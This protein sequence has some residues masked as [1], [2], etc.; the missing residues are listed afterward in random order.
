MRWTDLCSLAFSA[1]LRQ[2]TRTGLTL[3]GV[4]I[5]TFALVVTFSVGWGVQGEVL[6]QLRNNNQLRQVSVR[7]GPGKVEAEMPPD[8]LDVKGD[9]SDAKRARIR[10]ALIRDWA[11]RHNARPRVPLDRRRLGVL[12]RL[13]HVESVTPFV[14][15]PCRV[16]FHGKTLDVDC[17]SAAPDNRP[18]RQRVA[19][20][21]FLPAPAGRSVVVHEFLLYRVGIRTDDEVASVI[22]QPIRIEQRAR[23][24]TPTS[25]LTLFSTARADLTSREKEVLEKAVQRLPADAGKLGLS[26][27]DKKT[28]QE[29]FT[30]L[31]SHVPP[32][33]R[34]RFSEE[35]TIA[36]VLRG[37]EKGDHNTS[38]GL[39]SLVLEPDVVMPVHTAEAL[40]DRVPES[41]DE[42]EG[43]P[44]ATLTVDRE[45]NLAGVVQHVK[46]MG[47]N[48]FSLLKLVEQVRRNMTLMTFAV[49]FLAV[50][51]LLVS[52]LG[53]TNTM[54]MA[55][56]ERRKEI[57]IMKAVGARDRHIQLIF[58]LEGALIG[59]VGSAVGLLAAWL[60]S[61]P[62]DGVAR[63][64][65][66]EQ[67]QTTLNESLFVFPP[68]LT[69]G[70]P[71]LVV[72]VTTLAAVYPAR[73]AARTD[74][75]QALRQ[76]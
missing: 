58:L 71:L 35:F 38:L 41:A 21:E 16:T 62:G 53:I 31:P 8:A 12:A 5:G 14:H 60:A 73:R 27:A 72:L 2:K 26:P 64:L 29:L 1:L 15:Q 49:G 7:P 43:F 66:E 56:L 46:E 24:W 37:V 63:R 61:F 22:G 33:S 44:E 76:E 18:L 55:V 36:G 10:K 57:G 75:V 11:R 28:L 39:A 67:T 13:P 54:I 47:L 23:Q 65:M 34:V 52:D 19:A 32:A 74:P 45:E 17:F 25:L 69:L 20:G 6:R 3:V 30:R 4:V 59:L 9:L 40:F 50:V 42:L 70:A 48:E 68:W 51:A